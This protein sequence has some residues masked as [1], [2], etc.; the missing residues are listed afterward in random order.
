MN[1]VAIVADS[2]IS[3]PLEVAMKHGIAVIP[4]HVIMD[5]KSHLDIEVDRE[6]LYAQL[7][8]K[9]NLP[10]T[11]GYTAEEC[12]RVYQE[13]S[14]RAEAILQISMTSAFT[15]MGYNAAMKAKEIARGKLPNTTIEVIDSQA[16]GPALTLVV[17]EAAEAAA[18][19][20]SLR[21]VA[22]IASSVISRVNELEGSDTLFYLDKGG[23]IFQAKSWVEA[24]AKNSFRTIVE[25]DTSV[26]GLT[27]PVARA[28]TKTQIMEKMVDIAKER[29]GNK[30][31]HAAI[32]HTNVPDQAEQLREMVL[33]RFQCDE[34]YVNEASA[35][36]AVHNGEGLIEFGF[37]GSEE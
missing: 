6:Q 28:K 34:L 27:K 32:A 30:K 19:G 16:V 13:L 3:M 17:L 12:L 8:E 11:S 31:L 33:S 5:G 24:Q 4:F 15:A 21:E 1:K 26:G 7:R 22:E 10:T 36:T 9:G 20:K 25:I 23:R 37:Y 14:Q 2:T 35:P 29:V 18:Q